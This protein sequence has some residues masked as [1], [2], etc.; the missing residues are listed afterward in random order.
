[1]LPLE[2]CCN[3]ILVPGI[4]FGGCLSLTRYLLLRPHLLPTLSR[5]LSHLSSF[6][7]WTPLPSLPLLLQTVVLPS[8]THTLSEDPSILSRFLNYCVTFRTQDLLERDLTE[9]REYRVFVTNSIMF[10]MIL[11]LK[12]VGLELYKS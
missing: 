4:F 12:L 6:T 3:S 1:M 11:T 8:K 7:T 9:E 10:I 2:P 5:R